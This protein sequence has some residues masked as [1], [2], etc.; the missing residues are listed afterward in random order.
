MHS[1]QRIHACHASMKYTLR[2]MKIYMMS[3]VSFVLFQIINA[4]LRFFYLSISISKQKDN[5]H[6]KKHI[7]NIVQNYVC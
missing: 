5:L 3:Y 2:Q 4:S 6:P 7:V 1:D